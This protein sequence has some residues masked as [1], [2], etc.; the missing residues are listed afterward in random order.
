MP[1]NQKK[2]EYIDQ[3]IKD[4]PEKA[5]KTRTISCWRRRG[6]I[7]SDLYSFYD[8]FMKETHCWICSKKFTDSFDRCLDHDHDTGE[9]RYIACRKCNSYVFGLKHNIKGQFQPL[10]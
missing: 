5:H 10:G 7:D 3:W 2:K 6:V 8:F 4:N 1:Y 9:I